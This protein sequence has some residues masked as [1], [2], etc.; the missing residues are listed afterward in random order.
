MVWCGVA[1]CGTVCHSQCVA[2]VLPPGMSCI[3]AL[4]MAVVCHGMAWCTWHVMVVLC[5]G[6]LPPSMSCVVVWCTAVLYCIVL[7][8][9]MVRRSRRPWC[10][11]PGVSQSHVQHG[12]QKKKRKKKGHLP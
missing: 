12:K 10:I 2:V 5:C 4:C 6:T 9:G 1:W 3:G 7:C 8:C 11:V